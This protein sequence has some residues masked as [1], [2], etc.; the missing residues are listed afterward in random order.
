M[1]GVFAGL[2]VF[3]FPFNVSAVTYT[4]EAEV[5]FNFNSE[6]SVVVDY[7]DIEILNLAPGTSSDSN[8]VGISIG[9]NNIAGYTASATV[10]SLQNATTNMTHTN[11][12]NTFASIAT[13][14]S[15]AS[16]TTDNTWGYSTS[17]DNGTSWANF[18]G[19]PVYTDT[20]K[21]IAI[22]D[23]PAEDVIKF[24]IILFLV[25]I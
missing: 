24:K 19:L 14:A 17:T 12:T 6:I 4:S 2:V 13:D 21:Q 16:L 25:T 7:A 22:T 3:L 23:S 18:S 9:T 11:G 15:L 10:G 1:L 5:Q 8:I 20:A